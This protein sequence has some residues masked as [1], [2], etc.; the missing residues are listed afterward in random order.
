M[1]FLPVVCLLVVFSLALTDAHNRE[2]ANQGKSAECLL[3]EE[4][5]SLKKQNKELL[6]R[7]GQQGEYR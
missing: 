5:H 1:I 3:L 4:N 7:V 6:R 2:R